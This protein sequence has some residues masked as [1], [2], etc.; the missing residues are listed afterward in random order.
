MS[1]QVWVIVKDL[2]GSVAEKI[3]IGDPEEAE[4]EDLQSRKHIPW[5]NAVNSDASVGP[6]NGQA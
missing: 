1:F 6:F 4:A 5:G 3:N 2:F